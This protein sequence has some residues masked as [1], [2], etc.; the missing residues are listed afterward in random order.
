MFVYGRVF[1]D[2]PAQVDW[3]LT[4]SSVRFAQ[5]D[6]SSAGTNLNV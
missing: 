3:Y 1:K 4:L 2:Y 5:R 6:F